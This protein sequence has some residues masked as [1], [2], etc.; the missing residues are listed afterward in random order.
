[1]STN[2]AFGTTGIVPI[3]SFTEL[4][5]L[6]DINTARDRLNNGYN[7]KYPDIVLYFA[8]GSNAPSTSTSNALIDYIHKGGCVIFGTT[9][10]QFGNANTILN[11]IF[12]EQNAQVQTKSIANGQNDGRNIYQ[13]NNLPSDPIINGPFGN[14]V[15]KW[16][17]EDNS[18]SIIV[19]KLPAGSVQVCSAYCSYG[20]QRVDPDYSIVWYNDAKNFVY[21]GDCVA[22]SANSTDTGGW[23][24]IYANGFPKSKYFGW[25]ANNQQYV[26]NS[27][28]E[29]N[30]VA[31]LIKKAAVSGINPH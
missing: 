17:G 2:T 1:L 6:T 26:Y 7:G 19:T 29:L 23:P 22:A 21:F 5:S 25:G 27:A 3:V 12:G 20:K 15:G 28:L 9:D 31:Y 24:A 30:A 4:W 10:D 11:G 18:G 16:W 13:I 14:L 8:Y